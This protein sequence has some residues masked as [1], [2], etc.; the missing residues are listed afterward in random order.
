MHIWLD[1]DGAPGA[2][3]EI[4]FRASQRLSIPVTL[5]A[6]RPQATPRSRLIRSVVVASGLDVADDYIVAHVVAGDI[7][8]SSDIPLAAQVVEKGGV[9]ITPRGELLDANNVR[10]RLAIR[11]LR[12]AVQATGAM[13]GGPPPY[14]AVAR[15]R[16]ANALDRL[17]SQWAKAAAQGG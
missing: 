13:I 11:D 15:Q 9:V 5:V 8:V 14:D 1:A 3:R 6:N 12:E 10:E 2:M 4:L 16:F 7:V 17:L